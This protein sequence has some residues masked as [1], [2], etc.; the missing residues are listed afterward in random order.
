MLSYRVCFTK[1]APLFL[2]LRSMADD[3]VPCH[4]G[5]VAAT[6][7]LWQDIPVVVT[8]V[9]IRFENGDTQGDKKPGHSGS[10]GTVSRRGR[11]LVG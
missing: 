7:P 2:G 6:D 1:V 8:I 3:Q 9:I 4:Q 11:I 5:F 10:I